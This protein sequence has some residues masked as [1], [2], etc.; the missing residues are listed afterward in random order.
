MNKLKFFSGGHPLFYPT[1]L[2]FL[3]SGIS[4]AL[5][6]LCSIYGNS[7]IISGMLADG[8]GG[9]TSGYVVY[10]GEVMEVDAVSS[11]PV[12]DTPVF[13]P[14]ENVDPSIGAVVY[15]DSTAR[16][17][18]IVRKARLE[19][20]GA[21]SDYVL[22]SVMQRPIR[23]DRLTMQANF[24]TSNAQPP[25]V[26]CNL[27]RVQISG[28]VFFNN[29][30]STAGEVFFASIPLAFRP[31]ETKFFSVFGVVRNG[32]GREYWRIRLDV[33]GNLWCLDPIQGS[34]TDAN[35]DKLCLDNISFLIA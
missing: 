19:N 12:F 4:T 2:T 3:Q 35:R 22:F 17:C 34:T 23:S 18:H 6:G 24:T 21:Q 16:Q 8:S 32:T 7:W 27:N 28:T 33:N 20:L 10:K 1:D 5:Q 29:N 9:T 26:A 14:V 11:A 31:L 13:V 30:S 15:G 25:V